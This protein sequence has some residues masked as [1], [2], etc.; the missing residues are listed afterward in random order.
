LNNRRHLQYHF[1]LP[2]GGPDRAV[3]SRQLIPRPVVEWDLRLQ[4]EVGDALQAGALR[5][6]A[7]VMRLA[8]AASRALQVSALSK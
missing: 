1:S 2:F 8:C 6:D 5:A 3:A 7:V 4:P